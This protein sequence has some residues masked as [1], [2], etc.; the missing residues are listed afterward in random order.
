MNELHYVFDEYVIPLKLDYG[1]CE[2]KTKMA[3]EMKDLLTYLNVKEVHHE[4]RVQHSLQGKRS[5]KIQA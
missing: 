5:G 1:F 4:S 2:E 3:R